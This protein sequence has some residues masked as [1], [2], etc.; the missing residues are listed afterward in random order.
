ML[1]HDMKL[2]ATENKSKNDDDFFIKRR[3]MLVLRHPP[4]KSQHWIVN[5]NP[6]RIKMKQIRESYPIG[7]SFWPN[8]RRRNSNSPHIFCER[9]NFLENML[10]DVTQQNNNLNHRYPRLC[11]VR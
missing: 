9:S 11:G 7:L 1:Q 10:R 5:L 3:C 8:T 6:K 4:K 2:Y